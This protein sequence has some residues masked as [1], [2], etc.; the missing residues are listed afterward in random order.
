METRQER[1]ELAP[2]VRFAYFNVGKGSAVVAGVRDVNNMFYYAISMCSPLDRFERRTGKLQAYHRLFE[3][4][5]MPNGLR[6]RTLSGDIDVS[7]AELS[8][9][10][11]CQVLVIDHI[12][13]GRCPKWCN[14]LN[15]E[16]EVTFRVKKKVKDKRN[17]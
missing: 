11:I 6:N 17:V 16:K 7:E 12:Y 8:H 5:Q 15:P 10:E 1:K 4:A 13:A 14:K 9:G 2:E 3:Y